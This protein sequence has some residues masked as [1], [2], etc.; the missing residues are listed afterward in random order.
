MRSPNAKLPLPDPSGAPQLP[1]LREVRKDPRK[2]RRGWLW[3]VVLAAA[4]AGWFALRNTGKLSATAQQ[5]AEPAHKARAVAGVLERTLRVTGVTMAANAVNMRAPQMTGRRSGGGGMS[6]F[7]LTLLEIAPQGRRVKKG[8][9]VASFDQLYM[10]TR[11]DDY[12]AVRVVHENNVKVLRAGLTVRREAHRQRMGIAKGRMEKAALDLKT[13]PVRSAI[14]IE[15]LRLAYEEAQAQYRALVEQEKFLVESE[16]SSIRNT[17]LDLQDSQMEERRAQK[18]LDGMIKKAPIDGLALASAA[19]RGSDNAQIEAGDQISPGQLFMRIDDPSS[20]IVEAQANQVDVQDL[21]MGAR[22]QVRFDA[23]PGLELPA[24]LYSVDPI[25]TGSRYRPYFVKR[26]RVRLRLERTDP[27]VISDLTA[28]ADVVVESEKSSAI[29]PLE[30]VS[31]DPESGQTYTYV[32]EAG[33]WK[34]RDVE[35]GMRSYTSVSVASGLE[36][37]AVVAMGLIR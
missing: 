24:R 21:H 22:A 36:E 10:A 3:L 16:L 30:A 15:K 29:I 7:N 6:D 20:I 2:P 35:L 4:G 23:Y 14:M 28:N 32:E 33:G 13:A 8:D 34:R 11:L 5:E 1:G 18:N 12:R 17:Q 9:I 26:V 37:G 25:T 19:L 31:E 27:R